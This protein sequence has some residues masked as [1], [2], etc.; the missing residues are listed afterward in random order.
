[1]IA[2]SKGLDIAQNGAHDE[3]LDKLV[4]GGSFRA[5]E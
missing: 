2:A 1:M 3:L 4:D 5:L